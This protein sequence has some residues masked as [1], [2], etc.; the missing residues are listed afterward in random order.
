MVPPINK[1]P[2]T[3]VKFST[4][5]SNEKSVVPIAKIIPRIP[6]KFPLLEVSG[7]E[8]PLSARINKTPVRRYNDEAKFAD[9]IYLFFFFLYI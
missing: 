4:K 3:K 2:N 6:K 7:E 5:I 8:S 9:I 1:A